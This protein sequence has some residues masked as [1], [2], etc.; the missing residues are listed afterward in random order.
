MFSFA[1]NTGIPLLLESLGSSP[2]VVPLAV[3]LLG[4]Q[5]TLLLSFPTSHTYLQ[6]LHTAVVSL[7]TLNVFLRVLLRGLQVTHPLGIMVVLVH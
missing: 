2:L 5:N 1:Y 7:P 4:H 6:N 3:V